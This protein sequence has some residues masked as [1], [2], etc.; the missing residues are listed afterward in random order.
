LEGETAVDGTV[1][2]GVLTVVLLVAD[3]VPF[4]CTSLLAPVL[5]RVTVCVEALRVAV[6]VVVEAALPFTAAER[7]ALS[8]LFVATEEGLFGFTA[9]RVAVGVTAVPATFSYRSPNVRF[10]LLF[11]E[12]RVEVLPAPVLF[13]PATPP[14]TEPLCP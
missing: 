6:F 2:T 8:E 1:E 11:V 3:D 13:I 10:S 12:R 9:E 5:S 14:C 4:S 7:V